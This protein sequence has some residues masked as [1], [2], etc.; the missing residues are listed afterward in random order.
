M[1]DPESMD[2]FNIGPL[3]HDI[4]DGVRTQPGRTGL[5]FLAIAIG[6]MALTLLLAILNGLERKSAAIACEL[7]INVFGMVSRKQ[8]SGLNAATLAMLRANLPNSQSTGMI[9]AR[10]SCGGHAIRVIRTDTN[11]LDVRQSKLLAGRFLDQADLQARAR[12]AVISDPLAQRLRVRV[13]DVV[14]L[15]RT[16]FSIVGIVAGDSSALEGLGH[17]DHLVQGG[18]LALTPLTTPA[19]WDTS[20]RETSELSAIFI[21]SPDAPAKRLA[22]AQ[23]LLNQPDM[24]DTEVDWITLDSLL[25]GIRRW[26]HTIRLTVGS[27]AL[28]CLL[29]GGTT[30]MSL[31]V[32]N[33]RD[34]ITEIGLR[35]A[36]GANPGDIAALFVGEACLI[37][38]TAGV[39][40]MLLT[41]LLLLWFA[42]LFPAPF[43]LNAQ[44][45][46][47]PV[48]AAMILGIV[49]SYWPARSATRIQ[50]SEALRND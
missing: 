45:L 47:L 12:V 39:C 4:W 34:R 40:G 28:L 15:R 43:H 1:S 18:E 14:Q 50:P 10:T 36:L 25:Q 21:K 27:I 9:A 38:F 5:S 24:Q 23:R 49:F 42:P 20:E 35:R 17:T 6:I 32:A 46:G 8:E 11:W 33:V 19:Y 37:T 44:T 7:G 26:Q 29:L 31:M 16:P 48:M 22:T 30:L 2:L 13:G 3:L 41:H